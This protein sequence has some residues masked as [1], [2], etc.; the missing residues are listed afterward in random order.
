MTLDISKATV[1]LEYA[2]SED[3]VDT[4]YSSIDAALNTKVWEGETVRDCCTME[5]R[6]TMRDSKVTKIMFLYAA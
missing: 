4:Q 2:W 1:W 5:I 6:F 3:Y